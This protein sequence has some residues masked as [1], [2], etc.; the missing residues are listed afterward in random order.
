MF[1]LEVANFTCQTQKG[2]LN[3][4]E[5]ATGSWTVLFS[6]PANFTPVCTTEFGM[7]SK[8]KEE[9]DA[10]NTKVIGISRNSVD[11]HEAWIKDINETQET[12]VDF[13]IIADENAEIS[14]MLQFAKAGEEI[15]TRSLYIID[16]NRKVQLVLVYP[17]NTGRNFYEVL[18][19]I[20]SLQLTEYH[21]VG[22]PANWKQGEDV[23]ILP[24]VS[25][26]KAAEIFP[27]GFTTIKPYL[28]ITPMPDLA[29]GPLAT[30]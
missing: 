22:T 18:R 13:P 5:Y 12:E 15:K 27:K 10:R 6:H 11:S 30:D 7:V 20:D 14:S 9:Y 17:T 4:H 25:N 21:Q 23:V 8:L 24:H 26:E 2:E 1:V 19:C 28:R 16:P 29:S 3:F